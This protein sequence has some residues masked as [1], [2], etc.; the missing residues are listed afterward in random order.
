M[1]DIK[2]NVFGVGD[3]ESIY[4]LYISKKNCDKTCNMILV[5][6]HYVLIKDFNK[7]MNTQSKDG[8]KL[9][10]CDYC[11]QYL[12]SENILKNHTEVCLKIN[13]TQKVKMP[14]K[15][16]N[17]FFMNYHNQLMTPFVIYADFECINVPIK[18]KHGKQT[19]AYQEHEACG[20]GYKLVCQYDDKYS[21]PYK[22]YRGPDAIYK[23]IE[24]LLEEQ[25]EIKKIIK[26]N[27][28]KKMIIS[29]KKTI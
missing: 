24:N 16:K 12:T 25:K 6:N 22:G 15:N 7:L 2:F 19:V 9:F 8:H 4:P 27:F 3:K 13:G 21:K 28:N 20:Y 14:C 26:Q 17:I 1:N 18:E 10:F 11:L 23:L 29:K 5:E